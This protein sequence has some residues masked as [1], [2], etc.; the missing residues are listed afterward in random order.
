MSIFTLQITVDND[1]GRE[2][3]GNATWEGPG[4]ME[5]FIGH[6]TSPDNVLNGGVRFQSVTVDKDAVINSATLNIEVGSNSNSP[7]LA[8]FADDVDTAPAWSDTSRPSQITQT[9]A[10]VDMITAVGNNDHDVKAIIE[11]LTSRDG[12]SNGN[13]MRFGLIDEAGAGFNSLAFD[14][15]VTWTANVPATLTIDWSVAIAGVSLV[16]APIRPT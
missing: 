5:A 14:T 2:H 9:A 6:R 13:D 11:E 16:M 4:S 12:W 8:I 3:T 1:D 10:S 7:D 15:F